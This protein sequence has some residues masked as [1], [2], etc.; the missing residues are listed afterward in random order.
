[1]SSQDITTGQ[2]MTFPEQK[3]ELSKSRRS[4]L[5]GSIGFSD[6]R[7]VYQLDEAD[8]GRNKRARLNETTSSQNNSK[9][10]LQ[11]YSLPRSSAPCG[12]NLTH[13]LQQQQQQMAQTSMQHNGYQ[14]NTQDQFALQR[15][16]RPLA[17]LQDRHDAQVTTFLA[18][19]QA[20]QQGERQQ[21]HQHQQQQQYQQQLLRSHATKLNSM[22]T[23]NGKTYSK[24]PP[25][26]PPPQHLRDYNPNTNLRWRSENSDD[27]LGIINSGAVGSS[28]AQT[29]VKDSMRRRVPLPQ[30]IP[31][32][33]SNTIR[34][35]NSCSNLADDSRNPRYDLSSDD[36]VSCSL[37]VPL[38]Q[39]PVVGTYINHNTPTCTKD[40][41]L[42]V[43]SLPRP[44]HYSSIGRDDGTDYWPVMDEN[45]P[46]PQRSECSGGASPLLFS[47]PNNLIPNVSRPQ[48]S[49]STVHYDDGRSNLEP[50]RN[51]K[52][53]IY[54]S[55]RE[56]A[57]NSPPVFSRRCEWV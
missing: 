53:E 18:R 24:A 56:C 21:Q 10:K 8:E 55:H 26:L 27:N 31:F 34:L 54:S 1:M 48:S 46:S 32:G 19:Q 2:D 37:D 20:R 29:R 30:D 45:Y 51:T 12:F 9:G 5:Y 4:R 39:G 6:L 16:M 33:T 50:P 11:E 25:S 41:T 44:C 57:S 42:S 40:Q 15:Q 17:Q 52:V 35:P 22:S 3:S 23:P 36:L 7:S 38:N 14:D 49:P 43:A 28:N 13:G 47:I